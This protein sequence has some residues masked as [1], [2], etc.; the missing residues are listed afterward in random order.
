[1]SKHFVQNATLRKV[2]LGGYRVYARSHF[3]R[4]G[5]RVLVNSIPKAGT[6]LLTAELE[7]LDNLGNSRLHIETD[8]FTFS[9]R[10]NALGFPAVDLRKLQRAVETV[11]KGQFFSAHMYWSE[12]FEELMASNDVHQIFIARDPR[13]ILLSRMHYAMGLKRHRLHAFLT[14]RLSSDEERLRV[15][16]DGR[17]AD[18]FIRPF[19]ATLDGFLPWMSRDA[20]LAVR[21]EDLV[22]ERG[23]GSAQAKREALHRIARFCGL[24]VQRVDDLANRGTAPTPTMRKG[25]IG[26]WKD[27]MPSDIVKLV[28]DKLGDAISAFGYNPG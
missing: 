12:G 22:G 15:L 23:G 13:D 1:M 11:R 7:R 28:E 21:F 19:R 4:S 17:D 14:E 5:P 18:P 8:K 3:W 26:T 27:E 2:L 20:V 9:H 10:K 6:H 25:K 16:V 24:D